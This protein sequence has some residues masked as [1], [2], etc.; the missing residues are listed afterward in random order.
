MGRLNRSTGEQAG[1]QSDEPL[2]HRALAI[3]TLAS[4]IKRLD[5][6]DLK[7]LAELADEDG[8]VLS[9]LLVRRNGCS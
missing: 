5:V 6:D 4:Q 2:I 8:L 9:D 1:T 3:L 7:A